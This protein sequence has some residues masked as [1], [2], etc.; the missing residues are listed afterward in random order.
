M[1]EQVCGD[2]AA[3]AGYSWTRESLKAENN[4]LDDTEAAYSVGMISMIG[5]MLVSFPIQSWVLAMTHH[6][7]WQIEGQKEVDAVCGDHVPS[8]KD[9]QKLP[10]VRALIRETFRW[11]PPT[12]FGNPV[13]LNDC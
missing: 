1:K 11:R 3:T 10:V 13:L 12:P 7:E 6:P 8:M 9:I 2:G 5:G 4:Q